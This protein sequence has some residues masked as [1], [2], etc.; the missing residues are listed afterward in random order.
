[1]RICLVSQEYPPATGGGIATQTYL[2]AVGLVARGHETHV[3]TIQGDAPP[4]TGVEDGAVVHRLPSPVID[5]PA[6]DESTTWLEHSRAVAKAVHELAGSVDFEIVQFPEYGGEGFAY[7]CDTYTFRRS[8]YVVQLHGPLAMFAA[9]MGWPERGSA[10]HA[11]G[12][13]MEQCSLRFSDHLL[14]SSHN[15]ALFCA[16]TY[17]CRLDSIDVIHSGVDTEL[18][19]PRPR[20]PGSGPR[21]LF[22]GNLVGNKGLYVVAEAV[23]SLARRFPNVVLRV[24]G[25]GDGAE[26]RLRDMLDGSAELDFVGFVRYHDLPHHYAWS[27]LLALPATFEPGPGNV[28]LE[29]MA[30][31]RP[32]VACHTGGAGEVVLQRETGLLVAPGDP[33]AT[34]AAIAELAG[35]DNLR[36]ALGRR[37]REW[38]EQEFSLDRYLDKVERAYEAVAAAPVAR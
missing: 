13:F 6:L 7:Q 24:I 12:C 30:S 38:V 17:G 10:L 2:K 3:I 19:T 1:M 35:D 33:A 32:V 8:R 20:E 11:I 28:Y 15:T 37:G 18:F 21:V 25:R 5:D 14:A 26:R 27:D 34:E 9:H 23:A 29:A 4:S 36:L 22:V 31:G 16:E